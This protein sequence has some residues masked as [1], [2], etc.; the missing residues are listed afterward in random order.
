MDGFSP[1]DAL[2]IS[3]ENPGK[4]VGGRGRLG[5]GSDADL[6]RSHWKRV[7]RT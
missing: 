5:V 1:K 2:R 6:I 4:F 3:T 7:H